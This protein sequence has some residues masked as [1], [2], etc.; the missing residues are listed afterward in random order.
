MK[1]RVGVV[2]LG[3]AWETR[4][5]PA[6]RALADRYE[7][8][9]F[10][11][12]V[13]HRAAEVAQRWPAR[14]CDGFRALSE[15]EDIDAVLLLS[16]RWYGALP[17]LAACDAGKAIYCS[18]ALDLDTHEAEEVRQRVRDA[19][20]AFMAEF[21]CRLAPATLRLKELMATRLGRPRLLFCNRRHTSKGTTAAVYTSDMRQLIEMVDWCRDVVGEEATSVVGAAHA[22]LPAGCDHNE[23]PSKDYLVMTLDFSPAGEIGTGAVAQ[24]ACGSY[25]DQKWHE[26]AAF[27]RPADLQVVCQRGIAFLDLPHTVVWFDDAGQHSELLDHDR[28]VGEQ[29]LLHFHRQVSSLV[30]KTSSL[31]D[32]FKALTIVN[33]AQESYLQGHRVTLS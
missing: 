4:H 14:T 9:A 29:L 23:R 7:V 21:P 11:D 3:K 31:E 1:L 17:I 26:A 20:V 10:C 24:I 12:P 22:S 32:A 18:A 28:P 15:S 30:L 25:V 16:A 33:V 27:R 19:G 6:L 8:R 2:G 13:A 5:A